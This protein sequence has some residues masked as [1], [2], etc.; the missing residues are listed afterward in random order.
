VHHVIIVIVLDIFTL[1]HSDSFRHESMFILSLDSRRYY[2]YM[3]HITFA[4]VIY[5]TDV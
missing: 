4:C 3:L 5:H 2:I 1:L